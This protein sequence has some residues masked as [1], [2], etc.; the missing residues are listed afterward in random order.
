VVRG[1]M[2]DLKN[3]TVDEQEPVIVEDLEYLEFA[4]EI[5]HEM[6]FNGAYKGFTLR[7]SI[8]FSFPYSHYIDWLI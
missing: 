7:F 2:K 1:V 5:Y 3:V 4:A 6:E 8:L